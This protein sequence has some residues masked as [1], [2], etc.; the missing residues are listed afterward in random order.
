[1]AKGK[2]K[3]HNYLAEAL[4]GLSTW[5]DAEQRLKKVREQVETVLVEDGLSGVD[6]KDYITSVAKN[7][8]DD[9][10]RL[11][12]EGICDQGPWTYNPEE[13]LSVVQSNDFS[14]D[15]T[16]K[17]SGDFADDRTKAAYGHW[18]AHVLTEA[19][20][21]IAVTS[22]EQGKVVAVTRQDD[23]GQIQSIIWDCDGGVQSK[24]KFWPE[25]GKSDEQN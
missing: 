1:M 22:D 5:H 17:F 2:G 8:V 24:K 12:A 13:D 10:L 21:D 6:Y 16:I 7:R 9:E 20:L 18:L 4:K 19:A 25:Q 14:A 15:V 3:G 11:E 23:E